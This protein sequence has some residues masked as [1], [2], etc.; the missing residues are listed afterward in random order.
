MPQNLNQESVQNNLQEYITKIK[1]DLESH[2]RM[3]KLGTSQA[4]TDSAVLSED[5]YCDFLNVL[6]GWDLKNANI[7]RKGFPGVDLIDVDN[8]I[9]VQVSTVCSRNKIQDSIKKYDKDRSEKDGAWH[10]YFV[11]L[12]DTIPKYRDEFSVPHDIDF[13]PETDVLTDDQ[14]IQLARDKS[15]GNDKLYVDRLRSVSDTLDRLMRE[16]EDHDEVCSYLL[17]VL[18][19]KRASH[20]SF[21]LLGNDDI[22]RRLFPR[23]EESK[24]MPAV[25]GKDGA[26]AP[27]WDL[28][29][30][31]QK[32]SFRHIVIEGTGGI[33]KSV[34]LL[35]VTDRKEL[36]ERIPAIY[37]HMYDLVSDGKCS[38]ISEHIHNYYAHT[39][40]I[41]R[42]AS[43]GGK[44]KLMV[45]LDGLNEVAY[46]LQYKLMKDIEEWTNSNP[47]AQLII[48]S[49]PLPGKR[50]ENMLGREVSF[51]RLKQL[52]WN[53]VEQYLDSR[54]IPVP[55]EKSKL[56]ETIQLPLF[57]TLYAKTTRLDKETAFEEC[58]LHVKEAVGPASL[59][60]NFLQREVLR[61]QTENDVISYVLSC[62][63]IAPNIAYRMEANQIFEA[64]EKIA[65]QLVSEAVRS[66]KDSIDHER[67]PKHV[68]TVWEWFG[69]KTHSQDLPDM[70]WPTRVLDECGIFAPPV[71]KHEEHADSGKRSEAADYAFM[72]QN[73]RDCLA[74]LHLVNVAEA[75]DGELPEEWKKSIR[76]EVLEYS[77]ELMDKP[78]AAKLWELN[79]VYTQYTGK[80]AKDNASTYMQLELNRLL[81]TP[82]DRLDFSG[83]DLRGMSLTNYMGSGHDLGLFGKSGLSN[84]THIDRKVFEHAGHTGSV[85]CLAVLPDGRIV[86][87]SEDH[88]LRIWNPDTGACLRTLEG[89]VFGVNCLAVLPD[90]RIVS[91]SDDRTL[92]IWN[93]D[94]AKCLYTL[95]GHA[96]SINCLAVLPDGRIVSGSSDKTLRIWDPDTGKCLWVLRKRPAVRTRFL[97]NLPDG[98]I[99]CGSKDGTLFILDSNAVECLQMREDHDYLV[100]CL[101]V[102]PDGR[103]VV[104]STDGILRVW[105]P[106]TEKCL[107]KL[108]AL[109]DLITCLAILPDGRI[110]VGSTNGILRI[111]NPDTGE[112]LQTSEGHAD[113]V[114]CLAV[115]PDGRII[116]GSRDKTLRIWDSDTGDCLKTLTEH[117]RSARCLAVLP[118][119][120]LVSGL[121]DNTLRIWNADTGECLQ[122]LKGH[123]DLVRCLTV[124][125]DSRIVSGSYDATLRIWNADTGAYMDSLE[126]HTDWLRCL[127]VLSDERIISGSR[128][129]TIRVWDPGTGECLRTLT[130]H[131]DSVNCLAILP[132]GRIV[133]G[134]SDETIRIWKADTG[135]CLKQIKTRTSWRRWCFSLLNVILGE[136]FA[137]IIV[138]GAGSINCLVL[139][140]NKHIVSGSDDGIVRVWDVDTGKCLQTLKGHTD[141]VNCLAALSDGCVASGSDDETIRIWDPDTGKCLDVLEATEVDVSRMHLS[142]AV[143]DD[144]TIRIL[145][146]NMAQ[147]HGEF[148]KI[149]RDICDKR[150]ISRLRRFLFRVFGLGRPTGSR[151]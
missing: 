23:I 79:R 45:L 123:T 32:E 58:P 83:M 103:I 7:E 43:K 133:S 85:N 80:R 139:L 88:T 18:E 126:G 46:D 102:L 31:E 100:T 134:S 11:P 28:I 113:L 56:G 34:S 19:K 17:E 1:N 3:V 94:T 66:M 135:D 138:K 150:L 89:H 37:I 41:E 38:T 92:S 35:S 49:R 75:A 78:T 122:T 67:L 54:H 108:R 107:Q 118:D 48:A 29:E 63:M 93:P 33:G 86:S 130:G 64:G 112:H 129:T 22:D 144:D 71:K 55:E 136:E 91:G 59:I 142:N 106:N 26:V 137:E 127:A 143:M 25:G 105:N 40:K 97:A 73:F 44:P 68:C 111:W 104:G 74:A 98:R 96:K 30:K 145:Y 21:T 125:S 10:F 5:F 121:H 99:L 90:G 2:R 132:D 115:L 12:S 69:K 149:Y 62:E 51:I 82:G 9:I 13:N 114:S 87:G 72:H 20:P 131:T 42:L 15:R 27:I 60:W 36:L 14:I 8:G 52:E 16:Q 116:S 117:V 95:I 128:D 101:A 151:T 141:Q 4:L 119:G 146:Q 110:V 76:S 147:D 124:L 120:R 148:A 84:N 53:H 61:Q 39:D 77:A 109:S 47:G 24:V 70:N 57:L 140:H 81:G 65:T 50:L 6:M